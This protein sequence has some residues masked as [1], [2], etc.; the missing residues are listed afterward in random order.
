MRLPILSQIPRVEVGKKMAVAAIKKRGG[1]VERDE[2]A[3]GKPV[4]N[5]NLRGPPGPWMTDVDLKEL[6]R[7]KGVREL[8]L[9][10][11]GT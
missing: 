10:K 8:D 9:I 5:V 2:K 4:I 11:P 3:P 6:R 7:L 1:R